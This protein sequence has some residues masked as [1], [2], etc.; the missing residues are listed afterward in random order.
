MTFR[1]IFELITVGRPKANLTP[2]NNGLLVP[3]WVN[4]T[5]SI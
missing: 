4:K 5:G 2:W 1:L 3:L